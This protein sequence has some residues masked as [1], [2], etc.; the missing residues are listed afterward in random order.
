MGSVVWSLIDNGKLAN[1]IA[2]LVVI[3][4]KIQLALINCKFYL[5]C[6]CCF[7]LFLSLKV[8][9]LEGLISVAAFG[10]LI[11][12]N[13]DLDWNELQKIRHVHV[14]D[15]CLHGN[16]KLEMD[17]YCECSIINDLRVEG[18]F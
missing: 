2:R 8:R 10:T 13:N 17:A 12:A 11:L 15:L 1:H 9:S 7:Q 14:L 4:V 3:V 6:T 18:V 16:Q 5:H